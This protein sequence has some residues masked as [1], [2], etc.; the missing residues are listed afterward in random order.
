MNIIQIVLNI[1]GRFHKGFCALTPNFCALRPTFEKLFT[2]A[3]VRCKAQNFG[4][5]LKTVYEIEPRWLV[6]FGRKSRTVWHSA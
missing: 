4:E 3:K 5:G 6:T 1:W 2:S